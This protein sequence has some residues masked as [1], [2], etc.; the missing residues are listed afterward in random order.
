MLRRL[1]DEACWFHTSSEGRK[2]GYPFV[3][4]ILIDEGLERLSIVGMQ[5]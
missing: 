3:V 1:S 5:L 2:E 4:G